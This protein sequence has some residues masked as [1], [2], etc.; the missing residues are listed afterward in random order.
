MT[1]TLARQ[2]ARRAQIAQIKQPSLR[3]AVCFAELMKKLGGRGL[4]L[5]SITW[6]AALAWNSHA[7][8]CS[9]PLPE[10]VHVPDQIPQ[11]GLILGQLV[12]DDC[13]TDDLLFRTSAGEVE[14]SFITVTGLDDPT[15]F[16]FQP[17][18]PLPVSDQDDPLL[19]G[20]K[21]GNGGSA[22]AFIVAPNDEEPSA[23][24]TLSEASEQAGPL[25]RCEEYSAVTGG[26]CGP[27]DYSSQTLVRAALQ[28]DV[29]HDSQYFYRALYSSTQGET[30]LVGLLK[31][32]DRYVFEGEPD[33][34][35]YELQRVAVDGT[36][37]TVAEE[38][39]STEALELGTFDRA[40]GDAA[41]TL[42]Y[43]VVPPQGKEDDWCAHFAEAI[44]KQ[45]C[46][47]RPTDGCEAALLACD[48]PTTDPTGPGDDDTDE[49]TT[50]EGD[51]GVDDDTTGQSDDT[52]STAAESDTETDDGGDTATG[53]ASSSDSASDESGCSMSGPARS[54]MKT[55]WLTLPGVLLLALLAR[56]RS[57][58]LPV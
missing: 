32:V 45:D 37:V 26:L 19:V 7:E 15:F 2:A 49:T 44:A 36:T 46:E 22:I 41:M 29:E 21:D 38:C 56:R 28:I 1:D 3:H 4:V 42:D 20:L 58:K 33:E 35:C 50:T 40:F 31:D 48:P 5:S 16:A 39:T 10:A 23:K 13:S 17:V 30:Q 51:G 14:G 54:S 24:S 25:H 55:T 18:D 43:C 57:T 53:E 6:G 9:P 47:G 8:A 12:C 52:A 27:P 11:G 34:V